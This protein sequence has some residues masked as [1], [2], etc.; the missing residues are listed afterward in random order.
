MAGMTYAKAG[1]DIRGENSAISALVKVLERT[2]RFRKGKIGE[3]LTDI[4]LFA[5]VVKIDDER[6]LALSCDGVGTKIL[7]ARAMEKY[8][9]IGIDL[10]AM[11]AN[12]VICLGAEPFALLDYL[13]VA[14]P[15]PD[16]TREI[17]IGLARGAE[18]AGVC[19]AGGELAIVPEIVNGL[20]L[21]GM[22]VGSVRIDEIITGSGI[23]AGDIVIGIASTGIHSNGL[24]LARKILLGEYDIHDKIFDDRS[25]GEELLVPTRIYVKP[26]MALLDKLEIKGLA[27]I[28]GGGLDN[29]CRLTDKSFRL[30]FLPQPPAVF[31]GIQRLG[32]ISD[33][34]MYRTFNMGI[35]FCIMISPEEEDDAIEIL[36]K[37]RLKAWRLGRV[38]KRRQKV[39]KVKAGGRKFAIS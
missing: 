25:V 7:V 38:E 11:N 28:T 30:D 6:A 15:D 33:E 32:K 35:G 27:N 17:G 37:K 5:G 10:V 34:E 19:V 29:L 31:Q 1:V 39:V 26:V 24:T 9:T 2:K 8:D 22:I 4:G 21:A 13:A 12:D 36:E 23:K 20:D 3:S 16:V 14:K 18:E